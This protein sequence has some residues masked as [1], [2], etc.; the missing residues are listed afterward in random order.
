MIEIKMNN[1]NSLGDS[2]INEILKNKDPFNTYTIIFPNLLLEQWFKSY[3]LQKSKKVLLNVKFT[4]MVPFINQA[5]ENKKPIMTSDKMALLIADIL[6]N[7]ENKYQEISEYYKNNN[8]NLFDLSN[9][10]AMLF[11]KYE[12]DCFTPSGWQK[13]LLDELKQNDS[14]VFLS[15]VIDKEVAFNN[16]AFVFGFTKLEKLYSKAL[17]K[18]HECIVYYQENIKFNEKINICCAMSKEREIEYVHDEISKLL[19]NDVKMYDILVYAPNVGEYEAVIKKVFSTGGD[20]NFPSIPYVITSSNT[21]ASN[22]CEA[23]SLLYSV[24]ISNQFTREDF[25]DLIS[26]PN[27]CKARNIDPSKINDVIAAVANMNVFRNNQNCDEWLYGIKRLLVSKLIGKEFNNNVIKLDDGKYLPYGN[28]TLDDD[29]VS[30]VADIVTDIIEFKNLKSLDVNL[31]KQELDKWLSYSNEYEDNFYY[32]QAL[33][34]LNIIQDNNLNMPIDIVFKAMIEASKNINAMPSNVIN[35]GITFVNFSE[36]NILSSKYM[37]FIGLSENNL[38]RMDKNDELDQRIEKESI[39]LSDINTFNYLNANSNNKYY[40]YVKLNLKTLEEYPVSSLIENYEV[41][42]TL[43]LGERRKY[44]ELYSKSEFNKKSYNVNLTKNIDTV[45]KKYSPSEPPTQIKYKELSDYIEEG[46][47]AKVTRLFKD[48]DSSISLDKITESYE[49]LKIDSLS[50][51]NIKHDILYK[52]LEVNTSDLDEDQI[53]DIAEQYKM[54]HALPYI[55]ND[56][57]DQQ[58]EAS[59][60]F[61]TIKS[62][63][64]II[65]QYTIA[66]DKFELIVNTEFV[67]AQENGV[68]YFYDVRVKDYKT[69]SSFSRLYIIALS[70]L[71]KEGKYF[72]YDN[73]ITV[74]LCNK[75]LFECSSNKAKEILE[76]LYEKYTNNEMIISPIDAFNIK[77]YN[78]L[79]N[80]LSENGYWSYF[81]YSRIFNKREDCGVTWE[82]FNDWLTNYKQEISELVLFELEEK[83]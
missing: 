75:K 63:Y 23:I 25:Y 26:N 74:S 69:A 21:V 4:R 35:G 48:N 15:D 43:E 65:P 18:I 64:R 3:W 10:L 80:K 13:T 33:S 61:K 71:V 39:T 42:Q 14:Y 6:Y 2:L 59:K 38:P 50:Q 77:D 62:N 45:N 79:I 24:L 36:K 28:I 72:G 70:Y 11:T 17:S 8:A 67:Y 47:K 44:S 9:K 83:K 5:Y 31:I 37:F 54:T 40:S 49:P 16:K 29:T 12:L 73:N 58:E 66:L 60:Y 30:K 19:T 82:F 57:N 27:V 52:M 32:K 22:T 20:K 51:S 46:F 41:S 56:I 76:R 7:N 55:I 34:V 53:N 81:D 68:H 1:L 78:S